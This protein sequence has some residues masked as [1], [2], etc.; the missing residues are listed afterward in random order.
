MDFLQSA[1][2]AI[3][4]AAGQG[5]DVLKH[6]VGQV[7]GSAAL[8]PLGIGAGGPQSAFNRLSRGEL[9][10]APAGAA[11]PP[12]PT[13]AYG[14]SSISGLLRIAQEAGKTVAGTQPYTVTSYVG[15]ASA[16]VIAKNADIAD[17]FTSANTPAF[18]VS[19]SFP[20]S[21]QSSRMRWTYSAIAGQSVVSNGTVSANT[22]DPAW[23]ATLHAVFSGATELARVSLNNLGLRTTLNT[24]ALYVATT[25]TAAILE[26]DTQPGVAWP[27]FY[28]R[29]GVYAMSVRTDHATT[30]ATAFQLSC[31]LDGWVINDANILNNEAAIQSTIDD[32]VRNYGKT[33]SNSVSISTR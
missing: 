20:W 31:Q 9:F 25:G 26:L 14:P 5:E 2:A 30:A 21:F 32:L 28:D 10:G 29:T 6:V 22:G 3:K 23:I 33:G 4:E 27:V 24:V 16:T 18:T 8:N 15:L 1:F 13:S 7:V 12:M 11:P 17:M 19:D